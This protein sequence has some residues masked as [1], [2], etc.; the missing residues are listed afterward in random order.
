MK[1]ANRLAALFLTISLSVAL[2]SLLRANPTKYENNLFIEPHESQ[3]FEEGIWAPQKVWI[4]LSA[5]NKI[6]LH[7][8]D[9]HISTP[10]V[11]FENISQLS[12]KFTIPA[13]K[14][15]SIR[16]ENPRDEPTSIN[17]T[18]TFYD[19][20]TDLVTISTVTLTIG[21]AIPP[22]HYAKQ[23]LG[24]RPGKTATT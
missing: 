19:F 14:T 22:I 9:Q 10:I 16:V 21:I 4:Q 8:M 18:T 11:S 24:R 1:K 3:E 17:V 6:S 12:Y 20:E 13:R 5:E 2:V 23:R 15:Y 7:I